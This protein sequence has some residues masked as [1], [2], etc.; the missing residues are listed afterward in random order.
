MIKK[1]SNLLRDEVKPDEKGGGGGGAPKEE[2]KA[3]QDDKKNETPGK[4]FDEF[5]YEKKPTEPDDKKKEEE[6]PKDD[7]KPEEDKKVEPSASGYGKKP[8]EVP[9]EE[10]K[11]EEEKKTED[12]LEYEKDLDLKDV[13]PKIGESLKEFAKR[14]GL[15]KEQA[16]AVIDLKKSDM[17]VI[18]QVYE[19]EQ[20]RIN[21]EAIKLKASWDNELRTDRKFAGEK[22]D[23]FDASITRIDKVL[24]DFF[25]NMKNHLTKAGSVLPPYVMRDLLGLASHLYDTKPLPG[26]GGLPGSEEVD[27]KDGPVDHLDFYNSSKKS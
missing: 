8:L 15:T 2:S 21:D 24:V 5:G 3:P 12:K 18:K 14:T 22:L 25:P 4:E 10:L 11:K 13:D 6:K 9:K 27:K 26:E 23:Q 1:F 17:A 16:Q 20:K 7:K 19:D